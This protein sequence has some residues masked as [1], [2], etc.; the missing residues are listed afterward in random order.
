MYEL[1]RGRQ[2]GEVVSQNGLAGRIEFVLEEADQPD[3]E[4]VDES[5][6]GL[7]SFG[8]LDEGK[9]AVRFGLDSSD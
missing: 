5:D 2:V 6:T 4:K 3:P 1:S 9:E 8:P 7:D